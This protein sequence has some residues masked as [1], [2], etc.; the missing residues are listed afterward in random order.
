[1]AITDYASLQTAVLNWLNRSGDADA[2]TRVVEWISLAEDELKASLATMP[3]RQGEANDTAFAVSSEYITLPTGM[4]KVRGFVLNGLPPQPLDYASPNVIDRYVLVTG[5]VGKPKF[6]ATQGNQFRMIPAPDSAYTATL[7]YQAL[8]PL[9]VS[10]T[11]NWLL[12]AHPKIYLCATL[13]EAD[14]YYRDAD[15][16]AADTALWK[17]L[18]ASAYEADGPSSTGNAMRIRTDGGTP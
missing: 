8:A 11:T 18:F 3:L 13:A 1:M 9:S 15:A 6:Y 4:L 5:T 16:Y 14:R 2:T 17:R 12:T 10:N 7:N